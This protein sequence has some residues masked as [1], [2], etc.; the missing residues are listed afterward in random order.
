MLGRGLAN[1]Q[2]NVADL[3][4]SGGSNRAPSRQQ[5]KKKDRHAAVFRNPHQA[6]CDLGMPMPVPVMFRSRNTLW[7]KD[8]HP[9][10][11]RR[12]EAGTTKTQEI[13]AAGGAPDDVVKIQQRNET[14]EATGDTSSRASAGAQDH[15]RR[16]THRHRECA[17][18]NG[19]RKK[20]RADNGRA[21]ELTHNKPPENRAVLPSYRARCRGAFPDH[22]FGKVNAAA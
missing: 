11:D 10:R 16:V 9:R 21:H 6:L 17:G 22:S 7:R 2:P 15:R 4:L 12:S 1:G 20:Q 5:D 18:R 14:E 13:A 8:V 3:A 19:R